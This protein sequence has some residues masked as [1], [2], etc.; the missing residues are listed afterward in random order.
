MRVNG[1]LYYLLGD[2]LGS[3]SLTTNASGQVVSEMRYKAWGE[4]RYASGEMPTEYQYTDQFSYE[5][6]FGLMYYGARWYD[7]SLG[8]FNQPDLIIPPTQGVQAWDRYAYTSNN[9]LKY[10]DPTGHNACSDNKDCDPNKINPKVRFPP[11]PF[12]YDTLTVG[13][14]GILK[15]LIGFDADIEVVVNWKAV[16]E[17]ELQNFDASLNVGTSISGGASLEDA[18]GVEFYGHDG[19]VLEQSGFQLLGEDGQVP[20]NAGGCIDNVCGTALYTLDTSDP[21]NLNG[22]GFFVGVGLDP[23]GIDVSADVMGASDWVL[24]QKSS[25][26]PRA[27]I[28]F[29]NREFLRTV[30]FLGQFIH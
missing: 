15:E 21:D 5:S 19:T 3:T 16:K 12:A 11:N 23:A 10:T 28:P 17:G 14:H 6:Q 30:P 18:V 24:Y 25:E 1:T 2:H 13:F 8:R 9:P 20:V 7:P 26:P 29:F 27:Q 4:V 22:E